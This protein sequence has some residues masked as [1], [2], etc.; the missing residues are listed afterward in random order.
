MRLRGAEVS[1]VTQTPDR[2]H[3]NVS[4]MQR[5]T[6]ASY[7]HHFSVREKVTFVNTLLL[8]VPPADFK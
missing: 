6:S 8:Y 3:Q 2:E 7:A 5:S 4:G 1:A